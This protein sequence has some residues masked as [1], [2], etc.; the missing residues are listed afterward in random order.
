MQSLPSA[1]ISHISIT[2]GMSNRGTLSLRLG[3]ARLL[4]DFAGDYCT[5]RSCLLL[6]PHVKASQMFIKSEERVAEVYSRFEPVLPAKGRWRS[7]IPQI[8]FPV[9]FVLATV[10]KRLH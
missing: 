1:G 4:V 3:E 2:M 8:P 10:C 5:R 6:A 9:Q 7:N